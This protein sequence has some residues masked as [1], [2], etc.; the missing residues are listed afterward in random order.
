MMKGWLNVTPSLFLLTTV[1]MGVLA[2][3]L[4]IL[5]DRSLVQGVV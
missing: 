5:P 4:Y 2:E 3:G 1:R